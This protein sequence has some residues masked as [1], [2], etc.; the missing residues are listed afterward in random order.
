[1]R[2]TT[3]YLIRHG[4]TIGGDEYRYKGH[5]DIELSEK[6]KEQITVLA[7]QMY[8]NK[9]RLSALYCSDLKRALQS[10]EILS[11][12]LCV[13]I[14]EVPAL[15]ERNFGKWEG[16]SFDEISTVYPDEFNRWKEDPLRFHPPEGESTIE[17]KERAL[18]VIEDIL[19][20]HS[21]ESIGIMAHGGINRVI[22]C[23]FLG[24]PLY[25]LFRIEQDYGC[26]NIIDIYPDGNPVIR[27]MNYV[28][29]GGVY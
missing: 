9:I 3:L 19:K 28:P 7:R 11:K 2:K 25:N 6:G 27:L 16:M 23:H 18:N 21:G 5:T 17:V 1:M 20:K 8:N 26:L 15:R 22:L 10:A 13:E 4:H 24:V 12:V 14:T 29:Y